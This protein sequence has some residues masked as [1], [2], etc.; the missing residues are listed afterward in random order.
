MRVQTK[1]I[2]L[3]LILS[4]IFAA[5][6]YF[7]QLFEN[8]RMFVLFREDNAEKN[9]YFDNLI[10][11]KG[12]S[13]EALAFDYTYWDEMVDFIRGKNKAWAAANLNDDTLK[14]YEADAIWAYRPDLSLAHFT[15]K[16]NA[17]EL[18]GLPALKDVIKGVLQGERFCHFFMDTR[19]G[20]IE[21]RGATIHPTEDV[22]RITPPQGYFFCARLWNKEYTDELVKFTGGEIKTSPEKPPVLD[23]AALLKDNTIAFSRELS[24]W[25]GKTVSYAYISIESKLL[26]NYRLFSRNAAAIFIVF[27]VLVL[28]FVSIFLVTSVSAPLMA[29]SQALKTGKPPSPASLKDTSE[30]GDILRMIAG[31]FQQK[32]ALVR[33]INERKRMVEERENL[34]R[35]LKEQRELLKA[36]KQQLED[37]HRAIKNVADDLIQSKDA[38]EY[39]NKTLEEVNKELDDFTYIVSHDLKEPLRSIDAYS[40]FIADD[41]QDKLSAESKHYLGR[42]R[43][44]TERMKRLI[45]DLLDI[46]RLKRRGSAIAEVD[47]KELVEEAK[48]R[49]EYAIRQKGAQVKFGNELPKIFC[50]RVRMAEVFV[51]LVSNA[52]KF[53]DKQHPVI[54]IGCSEKDG[55]FEFYVKDN[56]IGIKKE[57]FEKIFEVFQRLG[58]REDTEG[59]GAGLTI[60]KKIVQMHRGK[61]WVESLPGE[62]TVFYFTIPREKSEVIGKK[63]IGEILLERNLISE[64]D[65]RKALEEQQD[66]GRAKEGGLDE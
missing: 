7:F 48:M 19:A 60:V 53:N 43:A 57:Y 17:S 59:T 39:Q 4:V 61:I 10:E 6:R 54:E 30:F 47:C 41:F 37:S 16:D 50:D 58:K 3:L 36:Q 20:L 29:V 56:G 55:F 26:K 22:K 8:Q 24:G 25:D 52:L 66:M 62:G 27:L 40:K 5:G 45:E 49:L 21:L 28:V 65:I 1:L 46:S 38:L 11:L 18:K 13:L 31:F 35:E 2:S 23:F 34:I 32:D 14:T 44:N 9:A 64:E 33:E 63:M 42:I 51:N 12:A 15:G